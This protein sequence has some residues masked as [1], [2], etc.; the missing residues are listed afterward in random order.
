MG[1]GGECDVVQVLRPEIPGADHLDEAAGGVTR[2]ADD[3]DERD[4]LLDAEELRIPLVGVDRAERLLAGSEVDAASAHRLVEGVVG[5]RGG[6]LGEPDGVRDIGGKKG[7]LDADAVLA[8]R[9]ETL[10][11][12][13]VLL[14]GI[15]LVVERRRGAVRVAGRQ[16]LEGEQRAPGGEPQAVD[17]LGESGEVRQLPFH[18][19]GV[20]EGPAA[21]TTCDDTAVHEGVEGL[22]D[23]GAAQ[24]VLAREHRF[25]RQEV[26]RLQFLA[27]DEV[28]DG[29]RELD[30][31]GLSA[32]CVVE[33]NSHGHRSSSFE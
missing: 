7:A 11:S 30:V 28:L 19:T 25:A 10:Q 4:A 5:L 20:D 26:A 27:G 17:V 13:E 23:R 21:L 14:P 12:D 2:G 6:R 3:F 29:A 18:R 8:H 1:V 16:H 22:D 15:S 31:Q 33:F 9:A 24:P 32:A